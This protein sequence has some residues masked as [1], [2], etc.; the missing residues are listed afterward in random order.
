MVLIRT[1]IPEYF[2][3][4]IRAM[5]HLSSLILSLA[6]LVL[7]SC[8]DMGDPLSC[9]SGYDC[10]GTCGGDATLDCAGICDGDAISDG[11]NCTNISYAATIQPLFITDELCTSCHVH[12]VSF[13]D[14][15]NILSKVEVG[16][17]TN[18]VL[19]KKLKGES[20]IRMPKNKDPVGN[21]IITLIATWIQEGAIDN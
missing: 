13:F 3:A 11:T 6:L 20:G 1:C 8:S 10:T 16:D 18:S 17:S 21:P 14:H 9:S 12:S 2:P 7:W 5:K 15:A 19:I 4:K